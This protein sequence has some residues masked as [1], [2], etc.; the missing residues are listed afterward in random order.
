LLARR[1]GL[2]RGH[3]S[4]PASPEQGLW[5][6]PRSPQ[7]AHLGPED[8]RQTTRIG[9]REAQDWPWRWYLRRSRSVSRRARGDRN[10]SAAEAWTVASG[11]AGF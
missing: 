8:L 6:A 9:I 5:L 7:W 1:F 11:A 2:D 3:D 10:P 4:Q